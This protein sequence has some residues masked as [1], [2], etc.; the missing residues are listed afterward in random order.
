MTAYMIALVDVTD[1]DRYQEYVRL[2]PA[3]GKKF[4]A[5]SLARGGD[6]E[7]KE[8]DINPGR[9][10]IIEFDSMETARAWY[11]SPEYQAAREHRVGAATFSMIL[12]DGL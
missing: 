12:V 9:V 10:V 4:H 7:V 2:A 1:P 3:A 5:K 6:M 8:G 11:D